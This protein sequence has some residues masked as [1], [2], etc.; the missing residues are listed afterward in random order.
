MSHKYIAQIRIV[1]ETQQFSA[2]PV[3]RCQRG[4]SMG[5][6]ELG[7]GQVPGF[8]SSSPWE[9]QGKYVDD[10]QYIIYV[11]IIRIKK[12]YI[13]RKMCTIK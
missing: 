6:P 5:Q 4:V 3:Y 8:Q 10:R 13:Y 7:R 12:T 2:Y 11:N 9:I 1:S